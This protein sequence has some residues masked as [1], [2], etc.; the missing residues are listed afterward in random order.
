PIDTFIVAGGSVRHLLLATQKPEL[1]AHIERIAKLARRV[2]SVCTGA[3]L[4]AATGLLEN[5]RATTHWAACDI[6]QQLYPA[7]RVERDPIYTQDGQIY[8]SAGASTGVD[9]SLALVR[10][11][12]GHELAQEIARWLV[13]YVQRPAGHAQLSVPLRA[14]EADR[15]PLRELQNYIVEHPAA[16]LSIA[17]LAARVGMS[18]RN[19]ARAFRREVAQTPAAYV[20]AVRVEAARSKLARSRASIDEVAREVGFG[21]TDALR[22]AFTRELGE[23]PA[24][25]R[26]KLVS[27]NA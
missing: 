4:L 5:K 13:L 2:A 25:Y 6:L 19:F 22:R 18:V 16:D 11:D 3:F 27:T 21:S 15:L 20:Q 10:E 7:V 9:L 1:L 26:A 24:A 12:H 17:T 23:S 14:Q 8:T